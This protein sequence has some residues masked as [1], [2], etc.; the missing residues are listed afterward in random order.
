MLRNGLGLSAAAVAGVAALD[1]LGSSAAA[2]DGD[3]VLV[4]QTMSP[5]AAGSAPTRILNPSTSTHA[6]VLFQV[7]NTTDA[8]LSLPTNTTAAIAATIAGHD[9]NPKNQSAVLGLSE[10]RHRGR[11]PLRRLRGRGRNLGVR[12]RRTRYLGQRNRRP[13]HLGQRPRGQRHVHQREGR[14]W[15]RRTPR[16]RSTRPRRPTSASPR[17][18]PSASSATAPAAAASASGPR[19]TSES[20]HKVSRLVSTRLPAPESRSRPRAPTERRAS[21][22]RRH[23]RAGYLSWGPSGQGDLDPGLWRVGRGGQPR[24]GGSRGRE[25]RRFGRGRLLTD[26]GWGKRQQP[27]RCRP[28]RLL[29]FGVT[30]LSKSTTGVSATASSGQGDDAGSTSGLGVHG[31]STSEPAS[32]RPATTGV[33]VVLKGGAAAVRLVPQSKA[34]HP[35]SGHHDRG[36]LL[37]DCERQTLAVHEGRHPRHLEAARRSSSRRAARAGARAGGPGR[38]SRRRGRGRLEDGAARGLEEAERGCRRACRPR[39]RTLSSPRQTPSTKARASQTAS[40]SSRGSRAASRSRSTCQ[41][42]A[43]KSATSQ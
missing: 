16:R 27:V 43:R 3:A 24:D 4:A 5:T 13:G 15:P 38:R 32:L 9:D 25:H 26:S 35:T 10:L 11:R 12:S 37:V 8:T 19:A 23:R 22:R 42:A 39:H 28:T 34:G 17:T 6:A 41:A 2:A 7:D 21:D 36:E 29:D 14:S 31:T 18:D 40:R 33:G 20:R 30:I 1:A